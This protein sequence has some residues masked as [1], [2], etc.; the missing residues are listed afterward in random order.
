MN[1]N[2]VDPVCSFFRTDPPEEESEGG[3]REA[4][5]DKYPYIIVPAKSIA[6]GRRAGIVRPRG[7]CSREIFRREV[8]SGGKDPYIIT[9]IQKEILL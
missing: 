7:K 8:L 9:A 6:A 1:Y 3:A 4:Y 5:N 2:S